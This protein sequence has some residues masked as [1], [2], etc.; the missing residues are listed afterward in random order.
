M[1]PGPLRF[2]ADVGDRADA[3]A[4]RRQRAR[5]GVILPKRGWPYVYLELGGFHDWTMGARCEPGEYD[6]G[7]D[8]I[9]ID[10]KPLL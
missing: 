3:A 1:V 4:V 6:P 5:C 7:R 9:L 2:V 8:A 10:R